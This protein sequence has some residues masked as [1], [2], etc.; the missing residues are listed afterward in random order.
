MPLIMKQE[1]RDDRQLLWIRA[2]EPGR[3]TAR[4]IVPKPL[5]KHAFLLN[6]QTVTA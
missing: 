2:M 4:G 5:R 3:K 1:T 6:I